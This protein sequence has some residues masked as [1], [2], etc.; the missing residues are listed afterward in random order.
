[1]VTVTKSDL[2]ALGY[3]PSFAADIIREAKKL[4]VEKGHTY[5][6]SRKLDRVP[7]EVV[8]ELLGIKLPD[9]Q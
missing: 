7:K 3:G 5:Y 4:M 2:I 6:Q 1:M 8:E 9:E